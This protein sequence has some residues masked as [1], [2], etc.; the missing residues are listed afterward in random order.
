MQYQIFTSCLCYTGLTCIQLF[1]FLDVNFAC[2]AEFFFLNYVLIL[3]CVCKRTASVIATQKLPLCGCARWEA[4]HHRM[5]CSAAQFGPKWG[6]TKSSCYFVFVCFFSQAH[7]GSLGWSIHVKFG[8]NSSPLNIAGCET[9]QWLL[10][11]KI[12]A[13]CLLLVRRT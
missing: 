7:M 6:L 10:I 5:C 9:A 2:L 12:I 8:I 3:S 4:V 1:F 13:I 11:T